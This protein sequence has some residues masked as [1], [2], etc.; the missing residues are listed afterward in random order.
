[1]NLAIAVLTFCDFKYNVLNWFITDHIVVSNIWTFHMC[2][3]SC[4]GLGH[5][6]QFV[7]DEVS[8]FT[9]TKLGLALFW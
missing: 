2:V 8:N 6:Y 5:T 3:E 4:P 1:M 9:S 7:I